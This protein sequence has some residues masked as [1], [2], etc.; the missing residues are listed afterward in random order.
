ME[1]PGLILFI[2]VV[3]TVV[4]SIS[5]YLLIDLLNKRIG[6]WRDYLKDTVEIQNARIDD[7]QQFMLDAIKIIGEDKSKS[8][9]TK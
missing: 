9:E 3:V 6:I 8:K 5:L 1:Q 2:S 7:L 4:M